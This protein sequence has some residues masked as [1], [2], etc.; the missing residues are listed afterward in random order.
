MQTLR[1]SEISTQLPCLHLRGSL[2]LPK[3]RK[4]GL[5]TLWGY[6]Q[7]LTALPRKLGLMA[8]MLL[9]VAVVRAGDLPSIAVADFTSERYTTWVR[10]LPDLIAE[11]L[12]NSKRFDVYE[13]DKFATIMKEQGLQAS[14]V[15][16]PQTSVE[17]GKVAGVHYIVTGKLID[18]G[19]ETKNFSGYGVHTRTTIWR[20]SANIKVVDVQSG[21]LV[22]S[23]TA[24]AEDKVSDSSGIH[25]YDTTMDSKLAEIVASKLV[26]AVLDDSSFKAADTSASAA[27]VPVTITSTPPQADVEVDG[28]FYGNAGDIIQ[29]PSGLHLINVTLPG[30]EP[31]SKKVSV[32]EGMSFNVTLTRKTDVR[33]EVEKKTI[34]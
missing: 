10:G 17:L 23:K 29:I 13:R 26:Q 28:V 6:T 12:V 31:W 30:Y 24:S 9:A 19:A 25:S 1:I 34:Q 18:F 2:I 21:K 11:G 7:V 27:L 15:V 20:L 3:R 16:D 14:G 33:I 32:K 4:T 5:Y 8:V 22:L